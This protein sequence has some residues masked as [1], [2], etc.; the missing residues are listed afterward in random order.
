MLIDGIR[1]TA[2]QYFITRTTF[3][4]IWTFAKTFLLKFQ[5][6][7]YLGHVRGQ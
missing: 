6:I 2:S 5:E 7:Y 3:Y 1:D 4:G